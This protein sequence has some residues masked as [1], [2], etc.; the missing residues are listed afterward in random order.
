MAMILYLVTFNNSHPLLQGAMNM[1]FDYKPLGSLR[2]AADFLQKLDQFRATGETA[3]I[4]Q[5]L[6][7]LA[8]EKNLN[9]REQ[10]LLESQT[11]KEQYLCHICNGTGKANECE[12][13]N[14]YKM[15]QDKYRSCRV[16]CLKES[17]LPYKWKGRLAPMEEKCRE[18]GGT[19]GRGNVKCYSCDGRGSKPLRGSGYGEH[20]YE[21]PD[22]NGT[23]YISGGRGLCIC[24][25]GKHGCELLQ[26]ID[27]ERFL[28]YVK[29]LNVI[30][31]KYG[32]SLDIPYQ[33]SHLKNLR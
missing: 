1:D 17:E 4:R 7:Q 15:R 18:C 27:T 31:S 2:D 33:L 20:I 30:H 24:C 8:K 9:P 26:G 22:C 25:H 3:K 19:G 11:L 16:G 23:G 32:V 21:C 14:S 29:K 6:E 10:C 5:L 13:C 28:E 12:T